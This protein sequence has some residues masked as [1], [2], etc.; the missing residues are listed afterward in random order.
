M[1]AALRSLLRVKLWLHNVTFLYYSLK[2]IKPNE[3]TKLFF[4]IGEGK[5]R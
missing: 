2:A 3:V 4:K 5:E 1:H